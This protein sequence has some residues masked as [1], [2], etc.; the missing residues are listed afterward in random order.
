MVGVWQ[1]RATARCCACS[2]RR[3]AACSVAA[4]P[5]ERGSGT[6][7]YHLPARPRDSPPQLMD[8]QPSEESGEVQRVPVDRAHEVEIQER[9]EP[10]QCH[11]LH[12]A[13]G[14]PR[15][16]RPGGKCPATGSTLSVSICVD[17]LE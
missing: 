2:W 14:I 13:S 8:A 1:V 4:L 7:I 16:L 9:A 15:A 12:V 5:G 17:R 3:C 11:P 6:R 10:R